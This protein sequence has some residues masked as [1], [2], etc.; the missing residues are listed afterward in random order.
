MTRQRV[1]SRLGILIVGLLGL[2]LV[3]AAAGARDQLF[4]PTK[5]VKGAATLRACIQRTGSEENVG[6]L[7]LC[8][9][10]PAVDGGRL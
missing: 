10:T 8:G 5:D 3:G 9:S 2:V 4:A 1:R 7:T 6:D